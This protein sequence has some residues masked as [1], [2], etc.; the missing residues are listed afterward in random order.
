MTD[1]ARDTAEILQPEPQK[2]KRGVPFKRGYDPRRNLKGVPANAIAAR[3]AIRKLGAEL[4][5]IKEKVYDPATG[6]HKEVE[7][8]LTRYEAMIRLMFSSKSSRDREILLKALAPGLLVDAVDVTSGGEKIVFEV[9][10]AHAKIPNSSADSPSK[11]GEL[12]GEPGE[13]QSHSSG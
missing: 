4:V 9:V 6:D 10:N 5:H 11:A 13:T 1:E 2:G 7:Y 8:D 3:K 12:P